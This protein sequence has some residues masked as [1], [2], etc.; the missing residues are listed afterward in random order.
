M[1]WSWLLRLLLVWL[2]LVW[3]VLIRF[4]VRVGV[5]AVWM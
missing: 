1:L 2:L 5:V 4:A 3:A